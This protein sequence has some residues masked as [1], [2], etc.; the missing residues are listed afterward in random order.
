MGPKLYIPCEELGASKLST[1]RFLSTHDMM[2]HEASEL[3]KS[4][5][6]YGH[7]TSLMHPWWGAR[8]YMTGLLKRQKLRGQEQLIVTKIIHGRDGTRIQDLRELIEFFIIFLQAFVFLQVFVCSLAILM[9][10][11]RSELYRAKRQEFSRSSQ[12]SVAIDYHSV[13]HVFA[14]HLIDK[15]N[16]FK[17]GLDKGHPFVRL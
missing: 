12:T 2:T 10:T 15:R 4:F 7:V 17:S 14:V 6:G 9:L 13:R 8:V 16:N 3:S 5:Y 1:Q 11:E